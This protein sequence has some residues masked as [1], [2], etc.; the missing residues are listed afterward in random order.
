ML[1]AKPLLFNPD[2]NIYNKSAQK[3]GAAPSSVLLSDTQVE[4]FFS[5]YHYL[6]CML[7]L[8]KRKEE[9]LRLVK[10]FE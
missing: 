10:T 3:K 1:E 9:L 7:A 8:I 5:G 2:N 6:Q 4:H